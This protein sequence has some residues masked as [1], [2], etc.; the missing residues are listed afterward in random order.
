MKVCVTDT[1]AMY[2]R[3]TVT[4]SMIVTVDMIMTMNV[5]VNCKCEYDCVTVSCGFYYVCD[6]DCD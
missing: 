4:V 2:I 1:W 6:Y 5:T 3:M